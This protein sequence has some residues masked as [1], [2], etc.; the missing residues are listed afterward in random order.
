MDDL[1][2]F[3]A[4]SAPL[5]ETAF[6]SAF[7]AM[8]NF[9]DKIVAIIVDFACALAKKIHSDAC[10]E[11]CSSSCARGDAIQNMVTKK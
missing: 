10:A 1:F 2:A 11:H 3:S 9:S 5:R 7:H 8:Q 6:D 4:T